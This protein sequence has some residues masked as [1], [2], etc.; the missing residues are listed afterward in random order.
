MVRETG[1]SP[2]PNILKATFTA[3]ASWSATATADPLGMP[4]R[5]IQPPFVIR[6]FPDRP[7]VRVRLLDGHAGEA[8]ERRI[9]K[10]TIRP[11][12]SAA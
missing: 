9:R 4:C 12:V 8:D 1:V 5:D 6:R 10:A 3:L 2:S 11:Q 7:R